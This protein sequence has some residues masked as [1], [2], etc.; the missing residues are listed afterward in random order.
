MA[1]AQTSP[2]DLEPNSLISITLIGFWA[3]T[4]YSPCERGCGA[5]AGRTSTISKVCGFELIGRV[6]GAVHRQDWRLFSEKRLMLHELLGWNA[7]GEPLE[8]LEHGSLIVAEARVGVAAKPF[9]IAVPAID[10]S[11]RPRR[12]RPRFLT[13]WRLGWRQAFARV[14]KGIWASGCRRRQCP[15]PRFAS[16]AGLI[17]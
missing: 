8:Q 9:V 15:M 12:R 10:R 3:S 4:S 5:V 13:P 16:S 1:T 7:F 17:A 11:P 2:S 6:P 14:S